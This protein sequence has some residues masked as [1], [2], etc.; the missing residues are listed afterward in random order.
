MLILGRPTLVSAGGSLAL[1]NVQFELD[2]SGKPNSD[3]WCLIE[4]TL[5]KE[6]RL[7]R[8]WLTIRNTAADLSALYNHVSFFKVDLPLGGSDAV[9]DESG[10]FRFRSKINDRTKFRCRS[11]R[12]FAF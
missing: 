9:L 4:S 3:D 5:T 12:V 2:L 10:I 1:S 11:N 8:C 6:I 7:I